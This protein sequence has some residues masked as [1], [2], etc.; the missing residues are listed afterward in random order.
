MPAEVGEW[1]HVCAVLDAERGRMSLYK[2]GVLLAETES[3]DRLFAELDPRSSPG[4]GIGNVQ[5]PGTHN[6]PFIGVLD[7]LQ[8]YRRALSQQEVEALANR[9]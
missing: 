7:E 6:M 1:Q 2:N 4:V 3:K 9:R 8:L 5:R